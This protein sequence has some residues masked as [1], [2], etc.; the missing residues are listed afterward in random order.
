MTPEK[1]LMWSNLGYI[2]FVALG[3]FGIYQLTTW[4]NA[5]KDRELQR[6]Q[7]EADTKIEQSQSQA[8]SAEAQAAA[9][10]ARAAEAQLELARIKAPRWIAPEDQQTL[11]A[12]LK[13]FAGQRYD[14]TVFQDGES[15]NLL[16]S[17]YSLLNAAGWVYTEGLAKDIAVSVTP[18]LKVKPSLLDGLGATIQV[19]MTS[20]STLRALFALKTGMDD[21]G[22]DFFAG[23]RHEP[24]EDAPSDLIVVYVGKKRL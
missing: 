17:I 4:V 7:A 9:A 8:A 10:N 12:R 13:P 21:A 16:W 5:A 2:V 15:R 11:V 1:V 24:I 18:D 23:G 14:L 19:D 22:L 20:E 3:S 6:F